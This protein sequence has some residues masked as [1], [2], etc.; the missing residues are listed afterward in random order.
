LLD[1]VVFATTDLP[2]AVARFAELTGID[3]SPGGSHPGLGTANYLVGLGG[4][5]YLEIIGPDHGQPAPEHAR[6]FTID[7]LTD[8]RIVTWAIRST[9]VDEQISAARAR[10]YDPGP[11]R[12]MSRS[13]LDGDLLQWRLTPPNLGVHDGLVPFLIDWGSTQHPTAR[14]LPQAPLI[15]WRASDP[16]PER[17]HAALSAL[18]ATLEIQPSNR[19]ALVAVLQGTHGTVVL[20]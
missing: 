2:A 14:P 15:S 12:S 5:A 10:G 8:D 7:S 20:T 4:G 13:T 18:G 16:K 11:A 6:P 3:P 9:N 1:H 19:T 17:L